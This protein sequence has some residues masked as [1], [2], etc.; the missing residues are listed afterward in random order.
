[1]FRVDIAGAMPT[2]ASLEHIR[3]HQRLPADHRSQLPDSGSVA[4]AC[5]G[6]PA[7]GS[8]PELE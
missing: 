7:A 6:A 8:P 3:S 1:V 4:V 5:L 2:G